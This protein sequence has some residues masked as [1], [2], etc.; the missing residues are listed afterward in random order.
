[1]DYCRSLKSAADRAGTR[2]INTQ[3]DNAYRHTSYD[4]AACV[5]LAESCGFRGIYSIELWDRNYEPADPVRAVS[6]M[7]RLILSQLS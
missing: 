5:R 2:I 1:M 4:V 3:I 7:R 6:E